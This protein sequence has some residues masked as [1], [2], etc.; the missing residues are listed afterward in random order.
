[1]HAFPIH[2]PEDYDRAM[3]VIASL[4]GATVGTPE[5][6]LL[7]VMATL[8]ELYESE[9]DTLGPGDPI[10][11]IHFK[12]RELGWT[13][14]ELARRLRWGSGRVS[15]ILTRKRP[16]T[17]AMVQQL[18]R[19]LG[20]RAGLLV[21]DQREESSEGMWVHLP[22]EQAIRASARASAQGRGTSEWVN[23][24]L[25]PHLK[26]PVLTAVQPSSGPYANLDIA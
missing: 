25:A 13:Q 2:T 5:S 10:E 4:W 18:S 7:A 26:G 16:L 17:L 9:H 14:N 3:E 24:A 12:L 1:M 15:E 6:D 21:H 23:D 8:V 20:I 22:T 19:A 11:V